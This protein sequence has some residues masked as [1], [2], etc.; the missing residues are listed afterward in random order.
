MKK[1]RVLAVIV[2][3]MAVVNFASADTIQGINVD[4]V[5]IGHAGNAGD[6]RVEAYPSGSG[7]VGYNYRIGT[8]EIT[9]DQWQTISN[10]A[11]IEGTG[12]WSGNQPAASISWYDAARFSNYL[13]TGNTEDGVYKFSGGLLTDI[14]GH[15][16]AGSTYGIA[17]F[18]PTENEWYKAAYFKHDGSGYSTYANGEEAIPAADNGW[19]YDGGDYSTPW[20]VGNV[21]TATQEQNGT[22]DMMGNVWEW[23]ETLIGSNRGIR[24]GSYGC[25][26]YQLRSSHQYD[27]Y[28]SY[29][30]VVG[31]LGFRVASVPEPA[32]LF[33]L[34]LGAVIL[35]KRK[36]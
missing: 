18:L 9:V 11:G 12:Y 7:A 24:G 10:A 29:R 22:F 26:D 31:G 33:L 25:Y 8:K 17:Y 13:T 35:R 20:D 36:K 16:Q 34:G 30:S 5:T 1:A 28:P 21:G 3:M 6:T 32:T 23:N 14:M 27:M 19:N 4:F 2:C 15:E